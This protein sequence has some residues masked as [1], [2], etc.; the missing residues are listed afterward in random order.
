MYT[1]RILENV[2]NSRLE[3]TG[4]KGGN[5]AASSIFIGMTPESTIHIKGPLRPLQY[6]AETRKSGEKDG[7]WK[8]ARA[9]RVSV[10]H[11]IS[12]EIRETRVC[13]LD[14][15]VHSDQFQPS[16]YSGEVYSVMDE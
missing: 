7:I 4:L 2:E 11:G 10:D 14:W 6:R 9:T 3:E 12:S 8:L 5:S 16:Y 15:E 13:A 1:R